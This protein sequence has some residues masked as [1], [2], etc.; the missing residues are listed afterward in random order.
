MAPIIIDRIELNT[1]TI[2]TDAPEADG[3]FEWRETTMV[4]VHATAGGVSGVGYTY[5]AAAAM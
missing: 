4:V 5:A 2:P 1:Y 3:T